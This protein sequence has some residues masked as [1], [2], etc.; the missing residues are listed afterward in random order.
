MLDRV[1][2]ADSVGW[3]ISEKLKAGEVGS[4]AAH[5]VNPID[6]ENSEGN[7]GVATR[8]YTSRRSCPFPGCSVIYPQPTV[9]GWA[10]R[11]ATLPGH[12]GA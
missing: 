2:T 5:K 6:F 12:R 10:C 3:R 11:W 7:I 9:Q 8:L 1:G 4:S